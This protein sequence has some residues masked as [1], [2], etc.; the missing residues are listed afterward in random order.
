MDLAKR[1]YVFLLASIFIGLPAA[2][3]AQA[4]SP[5]AAGGWTFQISPYLWAA[6]IKGTVGVSSRL[7]TADVDI[8]FSDVFNHIDWPAAVFIAAEA[9]S[10]DRRWGIFNDLEY[11]ELDASVPTRGPLFGDV[12][13]TQKNFTDTLELAYRFVDQPSIKLDGLAGARFYMVDNEFALTP[14]L[15]QGRD[16]SQSETWA[17]PVL[18]GRVIVPLGSSGF[19]LNAYGDVGGFGI[20]GDMTWQVYGGGGYNFNNWLTGYAAYRYLDVHHEDGG[21]IYDISQE[22]PLFGVGIHF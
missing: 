3:S 16:N 7:P 2:V 1:F 18:A 22:G 12:K 14:G 8:G 19:F 9:R 5:A 20:N 4:A 11:V 15:L 21:F 17:N 6:G 10:P 13:L